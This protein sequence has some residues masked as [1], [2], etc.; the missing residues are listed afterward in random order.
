MKNITEI[1]IKI[2]TFPITAIKWIFYGTLTYIFLFGI[3]FIIDRYVGWP[4]VIRPIRDSA[5]TITIGIVKKITPPLQ[6]LAK[7]FEAKEQD[8]ADATT[9][10]KIDETDNISGSI[11]D[12]QNVTNKLEQEEANIKKTEQPHHSLENTPIVQKLTENITTLQKSMET[13]SKR[14]NTQQKTNWSPRVL[15]TFFTLNI[16]FLVI[17]SYVLYQIIQRHPI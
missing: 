8:N 14:A 17:T 15:Y 5:L 3:G 11:V 16:L 13:M 10:N 1:I 7:K 9:I 12:E 4:P 6:K 2:I